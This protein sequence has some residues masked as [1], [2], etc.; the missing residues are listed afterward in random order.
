MGNIVSVE[1]M[2]DELTDECKAALRDAVANGRLGEC[3]CIGK[4][5]R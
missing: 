3:K 1:E 4:V 5:H 2:G